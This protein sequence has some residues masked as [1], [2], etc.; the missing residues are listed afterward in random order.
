[1]V[2]ILSYQGYTNQDYFEISCYTFQN[3]WEQHNKWQL[4]LPSMLSKENMHTLLVRMQ[5]SSSTM[6][7]NVSIPLQDVDWSTSRCSNTTFGHII[8]D[9]IILIQVSLLTQV[10]FCSIH[11]SLWKHYTCPSNWV[12]NKKKCCES[13]KWSITQVLKS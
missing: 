13:T 12:L 5:R 6:I 11:N 2:N 9:Y 7:I 3:D 10:H 1:M 4:M 8:N